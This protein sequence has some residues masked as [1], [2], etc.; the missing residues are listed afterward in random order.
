[1]PREISLKRPAAFSLGPTAKPKS[2]NPNLILKFGGH[3]MA[4]GLSI[5]KENFAVFKKVFNDF[6]QYPRAKKHQIN[7]VQIYQFQHFV[8]Q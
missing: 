2:K 5:K 3:A 7:S 4:A 8:C 6:Q 1:M